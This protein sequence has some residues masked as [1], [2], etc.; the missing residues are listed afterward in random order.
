MDNSNQENDINNTLLTSQDDS[1]KTPLE[2][3]QKEFMVKQSNKNVMN[4]QNSQKRSNHKVINVNQDNVNSPN[5]SN[6][7]KKSRGEFMNFLTASSDLFFLAYAVYVVN[8]ILI[9]KAV[10]PNDY[11]FKKLL[12]RCLKAC[13]AIKPM[14]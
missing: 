13:H 1:L 4:F 14:K 12:K 11:Y 9:I 2:E 8:L 5:N 7:F 3:Q 10:K 6:N